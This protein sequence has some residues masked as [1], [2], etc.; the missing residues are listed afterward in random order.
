MNKTE[1]T[2]AKADKVVG[3]RAC[4]YERYR[5][6]FAQGGK[7]FTTFLIEITFFDR[8]GDYPVSRS[9][10]SSSASPTRL[11]TTRRDEQVG[12]N[13]NHRFLGSPQINSRNSGQEHRYNEST[14]RGFLTLR[15]KSLYRQPEVVDAAPPRTTSRAPQSGFQISAAD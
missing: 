3:P 9:R 7:F 10:A 13:G 1:P 12:I 2:R 14:T 8:W 15:S 11:L 6:T 5:L 4:N